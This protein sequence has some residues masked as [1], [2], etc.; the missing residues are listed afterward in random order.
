MSD[1][2]DIT[3]ER[4]LESNGECAAADVSEVRRIE[5]IAGAVRRRRWSRADKAGIVVESLEPGANVSARR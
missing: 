5:L 1:L 4:K 3:L 2:F